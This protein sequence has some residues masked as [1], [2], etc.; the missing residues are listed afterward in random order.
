MKLSLY[1]SPSSSSRPILSLSANP[2]PPTSVLVGAAHKPTPSFPDREHHTVNFP[3]SARGIGKTPDAPRRQ[4]WQPWEPPEPPPG[5]R[6][7]RPEA[8]PP[9]DS[10]PE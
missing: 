3:D 2:S 4:H 9:Q 6:R 10:P 1:E 7:R 5:S 8:S